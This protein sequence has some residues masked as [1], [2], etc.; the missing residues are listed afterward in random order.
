MK[1]ASCL[2]RIHWLS[3]FMLKLTILLVMNE[4]LADFIKQIEQNWEYYIISLQV[5]AQL[6]SGRVLDSRLKGRGFEPHRARHINPSLVLVQ[7]RKACPFITERLL[8]GHKELN[9]ASKLNRIENIISLQA[10]QQGGEK[11][12]CLQKWKTYDRRLSGKK[13]YNYS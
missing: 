3:K 5:G 1:Q 4:Q 2:L 11:E 6:L 12:G 7:P 9:Q 10:H 13:S 8:M